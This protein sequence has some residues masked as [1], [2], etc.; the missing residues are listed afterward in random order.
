MDPLFSAQV[1]QPCDLCVTLVAQCHCEFCHKNL[2]NGCAIDHMCKSSE[3]K[4]KE[5]TPSSFT[6]SCLAGSHASNNSEQFCEDCDVPVCSACIASK[7]K[8]HK[9]VQIFNKS[10]VKRE[11]M[12]RDFKEVEKSLYPKH[13]ENELT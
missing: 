9:V 7:H 6:I 3:I 11:D 10:G 1:A 4:C 8:G 13:L 2:C 5:I 12:K